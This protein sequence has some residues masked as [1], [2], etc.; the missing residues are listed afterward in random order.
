MARE[1]TD[2][3]LLTLNGYGLTAL[4]NPS[5]C[6]GNHTVRQFVTGVRPAAGASCEQDRPTLHHHTDS[7]QLA[8]TETAVRSRARGRIAECRICCGT[9]SR[10]S[11]T[12]T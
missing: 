6:I 4:D 11:S 3:R 10:T 5:T 8:P 7:H 9:T 2:A 1:L 12:L